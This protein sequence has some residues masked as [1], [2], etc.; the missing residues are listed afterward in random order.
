MKRKLTI[1]AIGLVAVAALTAVYIAGWQNGS[2]G[3]GTALV[4]EAQAAGGVVKDPKGSAPDR[5]V[6]YPG[7][8][9]LAKNEI[10]LIACGTGMLSARRSQA[11][12][13]F[14]VE[15]GD[16]QKFLFDIGSGSHANLTALMI[17]SDFLT[18]IFLTHLHTD[19]WA[20]LV[21]LWAG[22]WTAGRTVPLEVWGPSGARDDMGTKYAVENMLK[23]YNWDYMTRAVTISPIPG[24][25]NI[26]E[27][28]YKGLNEVVYQADGVTV[29]SWPTIHTGDGPISYSLEWNGLK[30]V[31]GGDT[32]PNKWF[33][34]YA[35][36]SDLVIHEAWLTARTMMD[37]YGQPP[38]LAARIN[39][40]FHTSAQAFGKIMSIVKPRHAVAYHFFNDEDTRFEVYDGIR[41]TYDGP[42]SMADDMMV[43]NITKDKITERM[44]VSP[45]DAWDVPGPSKSPS[46]DRSRKSE[47]TKFTLDGKFD[48]SDVDGP[49]LKKFM[50][51]H[52]LT[53][54]DLKAGQ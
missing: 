34:K 47:Y 42:V 31:I 35:K 18:K 26:H 54:N 22:G 13:C 38:Q 39:L 2:I 25:I 7:T 45:D 24:S 51:K 37:K 33:L 32:A 36:D 4:K 29:R 6:Y 46:P 11:A 52:G 27:F 1:L 28:D 15:L 23:A 30:I 3:Q 44:A 50:N 49:W 10:R 40:T 43:W 9:P 5:Y 14:L 16:G 53:E 21:S 8:E 12:T 48:C 20:D 19:H 41:E 17:P